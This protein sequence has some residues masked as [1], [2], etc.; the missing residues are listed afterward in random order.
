MRSAAIDPRFSPQ[1]LS[2]YG[3][4]FSSIL[5]R[6]ASKLSN[7][8]I[9]F[10]PSSLFPTDQCM[11][12]GDADIDMPH[13]A[14]CPTLP[15]YL[16]Q[17][18]AHPHP[19]PSGPPSLPPI[20]APAFP[21]YKTLPLGAKKTIFF[22][23]PDSFGVRFGLIFLILVPPPETFWRRAGPLPLSGVRARPRGTEL[24]G[25]LPGHDV[26]LRGWAGKPCLGERPVFRGRCRGALA[27]RSHCPA[28]AAVPRVV[29]G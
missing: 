11:L 28:R 27:S 4:H 10:T 26:G 2:H 5:P 17:V 29:A 19:V 8:A 12:C 7:S 20:P 13:A 18:R 21:L 15:P 25:R 6:L 24:D 14:P 23:E 22:P 16:E 3:I 1:S 9:C